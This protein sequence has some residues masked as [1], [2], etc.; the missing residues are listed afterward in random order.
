MQLVSLRRRFY[1]LIKYK[2]DHP[3]I[4]VA[5]AFI[6]LGGTWGLSNKYSSVEIYSTQEVANQRG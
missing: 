2:V 5:E 1:A 4:F 6:L 3:G